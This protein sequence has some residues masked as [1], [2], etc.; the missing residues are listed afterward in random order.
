MADGPDQVFADRSRALFSLLSFGV[1][2]SRPLLHELA[3]P[4]AD[5]G[6]VDL[7]LGSEFGELF[8]ALDRRDSNL[9]LEFFGVVVPRAFSQFQSPSRHQADKLTFLSSPVGPLY[10][11]PIIPLLEIEWS[12]PKSFQIS[13]LCCSSII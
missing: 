9:E 10:Q 12:H 5:Q 3:L 6:L 1:K 8:L 11:V 4:V 7:E 2:N 13:A